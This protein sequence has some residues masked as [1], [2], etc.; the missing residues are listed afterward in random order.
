MKISGEEKKSLEIVLKCDS[1]GSLDV[2][3]SS[4]KAIHNPVVETKI[5]H[6]GVGSINKSD[7]MMAL[8]GSR[9]VVGFNVDLLPKIQKLCKEQGVEIR[10][11]DI[12]Y[13]LTEDYKRL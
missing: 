9:L 2:L 13:K 8:T 11:Y 4:L 7:L 1:V 10:L 12:I 3:I 5:I 6:S